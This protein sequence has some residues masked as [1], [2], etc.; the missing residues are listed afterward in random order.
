MLRVQAR[1]LENGNLVRHLDDAAQRVTAIARAHD[2]LYR[3]N[4]I[5]RMDLGEYI[6]GVCSDI[7][8]SIANIDV[9]A[10]RGV[11]IETDRAIPTALRSRLG[12]SARKSYDERQ[13]SKRTTWTTQRPE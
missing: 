1:N 10:E 2:Q 8:A 3:G 9:E 5:A 12:R 11:V 13:E 6:E 7:G 4:D